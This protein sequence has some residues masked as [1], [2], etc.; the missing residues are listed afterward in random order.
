MKKL[1]AY[2][3]GGLGDVWPAVSAIKTIIEKHQI[4]KFNILIITDSAYYFRYNYPRGLENFSLQMLHKISPNIIEVSP[5][6]N[7]NFNLSIDDTTDEL[8]QENADKM[9]NEFMFW[10]PLSLKRFVRQYLDENTIF[11]DSVFTECIMEWDFK[12][13]KYE[14]V[15]SE[16]AIFE[17][18]PSKIEKDYIDHLL[19]TPKHI[20]MHTRKKQEGDSYV[21]KDDFFNKIIKYCNE[22]NIYVIV[23]GTDSLL[24]E[25]DF[26]DLRDETPLSFEGMAY[27][28]NNCKVMLGNDSGFSALKLYQQQ[29]DNLL[30]MNYPRWSRSGWYFRAIKDKSNCLLL[31][32]RE[33]NIENIKKAIGDHYET[34]NR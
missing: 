4:S 13:R 31:D 15:E 25:G 24:L 28:I 27:L 30:I 14:R 19:S 11:I 26:N 18:K 16:R 33:D 23:V 8:S 9:V 2:I 10:R 34:N 3:R 22:K 5:F 21:E 12:N 29:K 1:V 32:A 20:L 7:D 17:F 6:I